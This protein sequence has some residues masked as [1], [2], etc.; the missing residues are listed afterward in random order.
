MFN[1]KQ[2]RKNI[3]LILAGSLALGVVYLGARLNLLTLSLVGIAM[4]ISLFVWS[5][6][7]VGNLLSSTDERDDDRAGGS[8]LVLIGLFF[9]VQELYI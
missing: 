1:I 7:K 9:I 5:S 3:T 4:F 6:F 8:G 2:I